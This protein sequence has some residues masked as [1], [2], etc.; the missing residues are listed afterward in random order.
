MYFKILFLNIEFNPHLVLRITR[1]EKMS[2]T[3]IQISIDFTDYL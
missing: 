2:V 3:Q 1:N